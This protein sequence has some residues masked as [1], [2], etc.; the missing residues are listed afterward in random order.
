MT[1]GEIKNA[2]MAKIDEL[3]AAGDKDSYYPQ[4]PAAAN[5]GMLLLA[6]AGKYFEKRMVL[7]CSPGQSPQRFPLYA[8][9][10]AFYRLKSLACEDG[11]AM[12]RPASEVIVE[13][14]KTVIA[15]AGMDGEI[16]VWYDAYPQ[17]ITE[18]TT[19]GARIELDPEAAALLP[20]Y[21]ASQ[22]FKHD[23]VQLATIWRNEFETGREALLY[24]AAEQPQGTGTC[25]PTGWWS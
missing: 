4:I 22:I 9:D 10:S 15:P 14:G 17:R 20:L 18:E 2:V 6:T 23:D 12:P 13:N 8:L 5:E 21:I 16:I 7:Q 11:D 24:R 25:E 1:Y 19:E 3:G